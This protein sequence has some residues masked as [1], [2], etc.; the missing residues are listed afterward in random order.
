MIVNRRK[1]CEEGVR[2]ASRE[3]YMTLRVRMRDERG[4]HIQQ[5]CS[6]ELPLESA[7]CGRHIS[8]RDEFFLMPSLPVPALFC[9]LF[10]RYRLILRHYA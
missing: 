2:S 6:A 10:L 9:R 5:G 8:P 3:E 7:Y 1:H 4:I